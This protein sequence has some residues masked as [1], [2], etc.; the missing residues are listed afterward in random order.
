MG[1]NMRWAKEPKTNTEASNPSCLDRRYEVLKRFR[2]IFKAVQ[3]HGQSVETRCGLSNGQLWV[4]WE[5]S[6]NPGMRVTELAEAMSI[7][8]TTASNLLDKLGRK[9]LVRRERISEDQRVV[10]LFLTDAGQE[11]LAQAPKPPRGILQNALF[12][13]PDGTLTL[14]ES[15]LDELIEM[16]DVQD[17]NAAMQPLELSNKYS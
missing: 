13:L 7:H 1:I 12:N 10:S 11:M 16:M 6:Q 3:Q 9:G 4:V 2:V 5:I 15:S 8:Q 14:L 17:E